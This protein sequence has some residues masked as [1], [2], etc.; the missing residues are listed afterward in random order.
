MD[1]NGHIILPSAIKKK[2]YGGSNYLNATVHENNY[3]VSDS[4]GGKG[5]RVDMEQH[6]F[7]VDSYGWYLSANPENSES[8]CEEYIWSYNET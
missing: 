6:E 3:S 4:M 2:V 5:Y 8:G 7:N 1:N